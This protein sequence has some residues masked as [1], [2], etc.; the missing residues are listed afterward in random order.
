M[1]HDLVVIGAGPA[2]MSAA[3]TAASLGLKTVL[4]DEQPRAG[5]QIYR[6]VTAVDPQ[7]AKLLGP[8]Y[9][10]GRSLADRQSKQTPI[11]QSGP[12]G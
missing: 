6:N 3:L 8:D 1:T 12:R 2:G 9:L 4:L 7:V 5:G 11:M 10:H